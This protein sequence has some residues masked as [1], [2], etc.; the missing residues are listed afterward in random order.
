MPTQ[1]LLADDHTI[2]REGLKAVLEREG[3][4]VAAEASDGQEAI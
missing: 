2:V 1:V 3:F 4:K